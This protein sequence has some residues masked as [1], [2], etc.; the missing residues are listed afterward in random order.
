MQLTI[1]EVIR[2]IHADLLTCRVE[3]FAFQSADDACRPTRH[4]VIVGVMQEFGRPPAPRKRAPSECELQ[5][6]EG[7]RR[8]R[9]PWHAHCGRRRAVGHV[10]HVLRQ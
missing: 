8:M 5:T 3:V 4:F 10:L 7:Q 6:G 2:C 1:D 9:L